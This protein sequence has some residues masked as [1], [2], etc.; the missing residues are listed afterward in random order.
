[1]TFSVISFFFAFYVIANKILISNI[2]LYVGISDLYF[3][4]V[5]KN[6]TR[7]LKRWKT[8]ILNI[9][10]YVWHFFEVIVRFQLYI[11]RVNDIKYYNPQYFEWRNTHIV[12]QSHTL[13]DHSLRYFEVINKPNVSYSDRLIGINVCLISIQIQLI[14]IHEQWSFC[15]IY[16]TKQSRATRYI[17][18]FK[19]RKLFYIEMDNIWASWKV[20]PGLKCSLFCKGGNAFSRTR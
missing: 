14:F 1:M 20:T 17:N 9:N 16:L 12:H 3:A 15:G 8:K 18:H 11:M 7:Y 13:I 10:K 4:I 6:W 19:V 5:M 2:H